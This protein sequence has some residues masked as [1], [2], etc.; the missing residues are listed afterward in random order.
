MGAPAC[1]WEQENQYEGTFC[2]S[3][4]PLHDPGGAEATAD[5]PHVP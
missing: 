5:V 3:L 2:A 4:H 1:T